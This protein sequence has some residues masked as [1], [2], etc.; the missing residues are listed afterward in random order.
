MLHNTCCIGRS[1][2]PF[3]GAGPLRFLWSIL[4]LLSWTP[5]AALA[6]VLFIS[7]WNQY[8]WPLM[9][10]T[11]AEMQ[12]VVIGIAHLVPSSGT[13]LPEWN[14]IMAAAILALLPPVL[15]ILV[16]QRGFVQGLVE[17]EK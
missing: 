2:C 15:V 13:Q 6:L 17:G 11:T 14:I 3:D 10:T 8:L 9:V 7:T 5:L 4:L 1:R 16:L 12:V